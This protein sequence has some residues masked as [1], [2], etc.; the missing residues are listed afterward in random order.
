MIHL[1]LQSDENMEY[2]T[3]HSASVNSHY[4]VKSTDTHA[5]INSNIHLPLYRLTHTLTDS[6][7]PPAALTRISTVGKIEIERGKR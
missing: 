7:G 3:H 1:M 4:G 2:R 5:N 6:Q